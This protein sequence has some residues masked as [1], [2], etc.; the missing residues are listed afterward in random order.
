MYLQKIAEN[1]RNL[2]KF[3]ENC[4]KLQKIVEICS[5]H[6]RCYNYL[7]K[8]F[9]I[10]FLSNKFRQKNVPTKN[11]S[12]CPFLSSQEGKSFTKNNTTYNKYKQVQTSTKT[13]QISS[14]T[15]LFTSN[16][17]TDTQMACT[18]LLMD[19]KLNEH[20]YFKF[21]NVKKDLF[22][23]FIPPCFGDCRRQR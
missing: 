1:C 23:L 6:W 13:I 19:L 9:Q 3:V 11:Q 22:F 15:C 21:E 17:T 18:E 2:Q 5:R 10:F 7:I 4:R 8:F 20:F 14:V 12:L 16:S